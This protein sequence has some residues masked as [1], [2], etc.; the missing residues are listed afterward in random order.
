MSVKFTLHGNRPV[1]GAAL[2]SGDQG[3]SGRRGVK[4]SEGRGSAAEQVGAS[5]IAGM[6]PKRSDGAR[7]VSWMLLPGSAGRRRKQSGSQYVHRFCEK[8]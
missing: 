6:C 4:R 8:C 3:G 7:T 1:V 5:S 2:T